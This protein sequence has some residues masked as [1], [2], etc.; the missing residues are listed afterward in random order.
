MSAKDAS[1]VFVVDIG[2]LD[3]ARSEGGASGAGCDGRNVVGELIRACVSSKVRTRTP[4]QR[5]HT[6]GLVLFGCAATSNDVAASALAEGGDGGE[7]AGIVCARALQPP[8]ADTGVAYESDVV[9]TPSDGDAVGDVAEALAVAC[10]SLIRRYAPEDANTAT[11]KR[12]AASVKDIILMTDAAG[13]R[14]MPRA[15]E[16][17]FV[18]TLLQGMRAQNIRLKVGVLNAEELSRAT[19]AAVSRAFIAETSDSNEAFAVLRD[20]CACLA[21]GDAGNESGVSGAFSL[22]CDLQ[23]KRVRPT[24]GFRGTLSFGFNA[25][26]NVALYKLNMEVAP[27]RLNKYSD[28]LAARPDESHKTMVD[29]A[30]RNVN[31]VDGD[32]VPVERHV[33]AYKYGKQHIPID[34][35]TESRL[36]MRFAKGMKVIGSIRLSEVPLWLTT[37]EPSICVAQQSSKTSGLSTERA[38]SDA[39]ALS[40]LARSLH[41]AELALLVR[42]AWANSTTSIHIGALTSR[43][44]PEGDFLLFT[45]MPF[46]E[47][48]NEYSLPHAPPKDRVEFNDPRLDAALDFVREHTLDD[49]VTMP[50]ETLNPVLRQYGRLFE[51]HAIGD[52]ASTA[53][54]E[55]LN[56]NVNVST[57][58]QFAECFELESARAVERSVRPRLEAT[59]EQRILRASPTEPAPS[60]PIAA[61][62]IVKVENAVCEPDELEAP[63]PTNLEFFDDMD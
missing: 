10:D 7:Y 27:A 41:D 54:C 42:G 5:E 11:R 44:T 36:S 57:A 23:L 63:S 25:C 62:E 16:D 3:R 4:S 50:W 56:F 28:E 38:E 22:L 52:H 19:S 58:K 30:F 24:P 31:D 35:E 32:L 17:E 6:C 29:V 12:L 47:D 48:Y 9:S 45:P 49:D 51:S 61:L 59:E 8:R 55:T 46:K 15:E 1:T 34:A 18:S 40:A 21:S 2:A 26:V 60:P 13:A 39:R 14:S 53:E 33:K 20:C 37:G 43:L